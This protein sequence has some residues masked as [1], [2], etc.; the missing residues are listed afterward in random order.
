MDGNEAPGEHRQLSQR[1]GIKTAVPVEARLTPT[2]PAHGEV[3]G[4]TD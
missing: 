3:N 2:E 4:Q 1:Q